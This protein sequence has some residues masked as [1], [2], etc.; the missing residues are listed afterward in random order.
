M[1]WNVLM[2]V[3]SETAYSFR[4]NNVIKERQPDNLFFN[5]LLT[6]WKMTRYLKSYLRHPEEPC[7]VFLLPL[8]ADF[9]HSFRL[10]NDLFSARRWTCDNSKWQTFPKRRCAP[11]AKQETHFLHT[12]L[13]L[14][15]FSFFFNADR[16]HPIHTAVFPWRLGL[17]EFFFFFPLKGGWPCCAG[18]WRFVC[19]AFLEDERDM[20][21]WAPCKL[22]ARKLSYP[23]T[24]C[25]VHPLLRSQVG[26]VERRE[27]T[28]ERRKQRLE[29]ARSSSSTPA[30]MGFVFQ[31]RWSV[32]KSVHIFPLRVILCSRCI[33]VKRAEARTLARLSLCS[34]PHFGLWDSVMTTTTTT[35]TKWVTGYLGAARRWNASPAS[36]ELILNF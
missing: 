12:N 17:Q 31:N 29:H 21:G 4:V 34:L 16:I 20:K 24:R 5:D 36:I 26:S 28:E 8:L 23:W 35:P 22:S 19:A 11:V 27:K 3:W 14:P 7:I 25:Q 9:L 6:T 15:T 1:C 32:P 10:L 2:C 13:T 30:L 18:L 33:I